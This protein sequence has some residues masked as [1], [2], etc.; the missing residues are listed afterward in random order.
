MDYKTL[1]AHIGNID[2]FL[3]DQ[4]LKGRFD[5]QMKIL[6]C[7][8]GEGRNLFYFLREGYD[9]FGVDKDAKALRM[10]HLWAKS[11]NIEA[12]GQRFVQASLEKMPFEDEKFDAI[13]CLSVLHF[14]ESEDH[15]FTMLHEMTRLLRK[16]GVLLI[17]MLT[18]IISTQNIKRINSGSTHTFSSR[19]LL[20]HDHFQ[21]IANSG[22]FEVVE[23][24]RI[25]SEPGVQDMAYFVLKKK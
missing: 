1:N 19:F 15:F 24:L 14:A 4:I 21:S 17:G 9:M 20:R 18:D 8:C 7:G 13:L 6:D 10:L 2:L 23:N 12:I 11:F 25:H 3:L 22:I 5:A 16:D